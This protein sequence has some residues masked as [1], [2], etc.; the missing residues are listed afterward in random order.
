MVGSG[1]RLEFHR[2][3]GLGKVR[4][5]ACQSFGRLG[6]L[7]S[8]AAVSKLAWPLFK[9]SDGRLGSASRTLE[10]LGRPRSKKP[11]Q[12][13]HTKRAIHGTST[14]ACQPS[15][16]ITFWKGLPEECCHGTARPFPPMRHL[17]RDG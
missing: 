17:N 14:C 15:K 7:I 8:I 16:T 4:G 10:A 9:M 5:L 1:I 2:L 12:C 3:Q 6:G 13:E 11:L